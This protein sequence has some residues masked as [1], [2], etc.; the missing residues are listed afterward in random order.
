MTADLGHLLPE[1]QQETTLS[2]EERIRRIR[3]DRWISYPRAESI[4][5]RIA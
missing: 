4:L 1:Y 3:L 5:G 2:D